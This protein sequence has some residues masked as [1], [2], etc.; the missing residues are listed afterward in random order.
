MGEWHG[1]IW[2]GYED[3]EWN[4]IPLPII[5]LPKYFCPA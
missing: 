4:L 3:N 2:Q 1:N 5:P